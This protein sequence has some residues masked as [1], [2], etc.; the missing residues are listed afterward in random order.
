M[1]GMNLR[2]P[3]RFV[4]TLIVGLGLALGLGCLPACKKGEKIDPLVKD[5]LAKLTEYRDR[6]CA[7]E[8]FA[9]AD[10]VQKE[11]GRWMLDNA[12]TLSE[13][14]KKATPKQNAAGQQLGT[15]INECAKKLA[16][17]KSE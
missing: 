2:V 4:P 9:C 5:T 15:E 11:M 17:K 6:A 10:K 12:Q 1:V 13:L 8:D 14:D 16:A 7:C 3:S